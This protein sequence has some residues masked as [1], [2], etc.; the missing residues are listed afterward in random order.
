M[1]TRFGRFVGERQVGSPLAAMLGGQISLSADCHYVML[2]RT[3]A[4][5][6]KRK[7]NSGGLGRTPLGSSARFARSGG[8]EERDRERD[9]ID[10]A[11]ERERERER[12]KGESSPQERERERERTRE[13]GEQ[14][15][16]ETG[17]PS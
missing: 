11:R 4:T 3:T 7:G 9:E 13:R 8:G 17:S 12:V 10:T 14:P 16:R 2:R 5:R 15:Q 1:D 6:R